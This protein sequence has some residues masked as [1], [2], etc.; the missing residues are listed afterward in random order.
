MNVFTQGTADRQLEGQ[1]PLQE[2][3]YRPDPDGRF[4]GVLDVFGD[5]SLWA[6]WVPGHTRGSTAYLARTTH[7]PVLFVGDTSHT[8]WGWM[9]GVER[10]L[11]TADQKKNADSLSRLERLVAEHPRIDVR[12][13]HQYLKAD[14]IVAR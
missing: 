3:A 6:I 1:G 14:D 11:F 8:S 4:D 13:G 5:G 10:G 7:G 12:L 2:W 9:E